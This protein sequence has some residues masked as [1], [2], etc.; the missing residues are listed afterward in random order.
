MNINNHIYALLIGV[1][2]YV[3][4]NITNLPSYQMDLILIASALINGLKCNQD[5]IRIMAGENGNGIVN[6]N[7]FVREIG[8][9]GKRLSEQDTFV[10]YFSGH[11]SAKTLAFSNLQLDQ[12]SVI[13]YI[14]KITCKNKVHLF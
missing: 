4:L 10:F 7:D 2:N 3:E 1:G 11:G 13:D 12:Q 9:F 5:N 6:V 8:G 14:D